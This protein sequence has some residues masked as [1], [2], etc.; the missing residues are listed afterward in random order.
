MA[1]ARQV[2][3]VERRHLQTETSKQDQRA[4]IGTGRV[5]RRN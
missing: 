2:S 5:G 3:A 1:E 4:I